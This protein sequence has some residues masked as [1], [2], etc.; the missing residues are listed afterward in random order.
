MT[1]YFTLIG[2]KAPPATRDSSE[3][4][5]ALNQRRYPYTGNGGHSWC[6]SS[7]LSL[8]ELFTLDEAMNVARSAPQ[9]AHYHAEVIYLL[10]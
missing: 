9:G 10:P 3:D 4:A 5:C 8:V 1:V 7:S 6:L 2:D